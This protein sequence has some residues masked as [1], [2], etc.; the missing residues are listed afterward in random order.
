MDKEIINKRTFHHPFGSGL[1]PVKQYGENIVPIGSFY[2]EQEV[3]EVLNHRI[4]DSLLPFSKRLEDSLFFNN[5]NYSFEYI[6]ALSSPFTRFDSN[7]KWKIGSNKV[8][9]EELFVILKDENNWIEPDRWGFSL[10]IDCHRGSETW[11]AQIN[12]YLEKILWN[13]E[14]EEEEYPVWHIWID[15]LCHNI[16]E[17][18]NTEFIQKAV[19]KVHWWLQRD[20]DLTYK[21]LTPELE[22][23]YYSNPT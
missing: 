23:K 20:Y 18:F 6:V 9:R 22:N 12:T 17:K 19:D 5:Y 14:L 4:S 16:E 10:N 7:Y 13:H 11:G 8:N 2:E 15:D 21:K 1:Y 3:L